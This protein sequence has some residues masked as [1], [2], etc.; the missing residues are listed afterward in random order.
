MSLRNEI[1]ANKSLFL[2]VG[3]FSRSIAY[4]KDECNSLEAFLKNRPT[5]KKDILDTCKFH[6]L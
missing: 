4:R 5:V 6:E 3:K 1:R 2:N